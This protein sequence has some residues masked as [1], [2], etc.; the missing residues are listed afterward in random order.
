[1]PTYNPTVLGLLNVNCYGEMS[2]PTVELIN[3]ETGKITKATFNKKFTVNQNKPIQSFFNSLETNFE[4]LSNSK[5]KSITYTKRHE[6]DTAGSMQNM[7]LE[8]NE[9]LRI[10]YDWTTRTGRLTTNFTVLNQ[11]LAFASFFASSGKQ[12]SN[13]DT[14]SV[15]TVT[16]RGRNLITIE[17]NSSATFTVNYDLYFYILIGF[18]NGQIGRLQVPIVRTV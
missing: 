17:I 13:F 2:L 16:D 12:I 6:I 9:A 10:V 11:P 18:A 8:T 5:V 3:P 14:P 7:V 15:Y 1:M 4:T